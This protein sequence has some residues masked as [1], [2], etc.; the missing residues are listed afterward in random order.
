MEY[1]RTQANTPCQPVT[2]T[3]CKQRIP[4]FCRR[5]F[6]AYDKQSHEIGRVMKLGPGLMA[7]A[8]LSINV[9]W[10]EGQLWHLCLWPR[11]FTIIA[12]VSTCLWLA[13]F[14]WA[15]LPCLNGKGTKQ[16]L[17]Y[18]WIL[19]IASVHA[20]GLDS[21][22]VDSIAEDDSDVPQRLT[23]LHDDYRGVPSN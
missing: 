20:W 17:S 5:Q 4:R 12:F 23:L 1:E 16:C 9:C 2:Y 18:L 11:Y 22:S 15:G 19:E 14:E 10:F 3:W 7:L 6:F 21:E 13:K 8:F